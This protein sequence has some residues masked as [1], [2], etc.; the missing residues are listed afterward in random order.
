MKREYKKITLNVLLEGDQEGNELKAQL[1]SY[2]ASNPLKYVNL[3]NMAYD[4][5]DYVHKPKH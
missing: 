5:S 3:H 2:I 1:L 4:I